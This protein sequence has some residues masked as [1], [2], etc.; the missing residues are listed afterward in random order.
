MKKKKKKFIEKLK[1]KKKKRLDR[2]AVPTKGVYTTASLGQKGL[3]C[4][5]TGVKTCCV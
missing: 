1:K 4:S 2:E 3:A 5:H